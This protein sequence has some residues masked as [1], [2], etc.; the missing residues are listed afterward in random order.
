MP[1][2]LEIKVCEIEKPG[3]DAGLFLRPQQSRSDFLYHA[4]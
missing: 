2:H 4:R 3:G 1:W